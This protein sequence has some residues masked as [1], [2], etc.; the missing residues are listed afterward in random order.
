MYQIS[1]K[2]SIS[3]GKRAF[4]VPASN[5]Q[6]NRRKKVHLKNSSQHFLSLP[7]VYYRFFF[8]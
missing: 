8:L 6:G 5:C 3:A 2:F 7:H 4:T 1:E